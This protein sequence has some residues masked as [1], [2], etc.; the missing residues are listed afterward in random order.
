V[1]FESLAFRVNEGARL[2][3]LLNDGTWVKAKLLAVR[4]DLLQ[5]R[6]GDRRLDL[7]EDDVWEVWTRPRGARTG[8]LVGLGVG[9]GL[10]ALG[11]LGNSDCDNP[12]S[13]C[14]Q[15]GGPFT[16]GE[17][18]ALTGLSGAIGALVGAMVGAGGTLVYVG[19]PPARPP[20]AP[21]AA[22]RAATFGVGVTLRF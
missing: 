3:V 6:A 14:A 17:A 5:L 22:G 21:S 18:A 8:F 11:A 7:R 15:T 10:S 16:F 1:N 9:A 13:E 4:P 20:V 19:N 2:R 12:L